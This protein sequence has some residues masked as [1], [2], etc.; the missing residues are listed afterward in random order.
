MKVSLRFLFRY[1]QL[2]GELLRSFSKEKPG[3]NIAFSPFSIISTLS[4]LADG[5][6]KTGA[7]MNY[8]MLFRTDMIPVSILKNT[9]G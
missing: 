4:V 3:E 1:N 2:A 9:T 6:A 7:R 8:I 5:S